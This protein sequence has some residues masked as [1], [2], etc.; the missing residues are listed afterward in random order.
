MYKNYSDFPSLHHDVRDFTTFKNAFLEIWKIVRDTVSQIQNPAFQAKKKFQWSKLDLE[1]TYESLGQ[2]QDAGRLIPLM[3]QE[4]PL[5]RKCVKN[6][7][8]LLWDEDLVAFFVLWISAGVITL[9]STSWSQVFIELEAK[10]LW[11][12]QVEMAELISN[13]WWKERYKA[14]LA[15]DYFT[16]WTDADELEKNWKR[17]IRIREKHKDTWWI[18]YT[19]TLKRK[20]ATR[21]D[22]YTKLIQKYAS[23]MDEDIDISQ[24]KRK[25]KALLEQEFHIHDHLWFRQILASAWLHMSR[26]KIKFR[27]SSRFKWGKAE[28]DSYFWEPNI[29]PFAELESPSEEILDMMIELLKLSDKTPLITWSEWVFEKYGVADSYLNYS[30]TDPRVN[31][32]VMQIR[33]AILNRWLSK[34]QWWHFRMYDSFN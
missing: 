2:A 4:Y 20:P 16:F 31:N 19:L 14:L 27:R 7:Y 11:I 34:M 29:P 25:M 30:Q 1:S 13:F 8:R 10:F 22:E 9:D 17:Q 23:S 3:Q 26:S 6:L 21:T 15:D 5:D 32:E 18:D 24:I 33:N 12:N 28:D